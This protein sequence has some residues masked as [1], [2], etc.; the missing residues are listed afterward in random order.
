MMRSRQW[1]W[2]LMRDAGT[3]DAA[4]HWRKLAAEAEH[5]RCRVRDDQARLIL[6]HIV[7]GYLLLA[8]RAEAMHRA[9]PAQSCGG[10]PGPGATITPHFKGV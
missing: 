4:E 3:L 7:L 5:A 2:G 9:Q 8:R 1:W 10:L 6:H